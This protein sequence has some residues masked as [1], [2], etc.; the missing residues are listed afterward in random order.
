MLQQW[1][2]KDWTALNENQIT[3]FSH[4]PFSHMSEQSLEVIF[5]AS[6]VAIYVVSYTAAVKETKT[7]VE[8]KYNTDYGNVLLNNY[9]Y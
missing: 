9:P 4:K 5:C 6:S 7:V 2:I 8:M 3:N 1:N